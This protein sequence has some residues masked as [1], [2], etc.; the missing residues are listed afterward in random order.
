MRIM[1]TGAAG[2]L[3][4][5]LQEALDPLGEV[6]SVDVADFDITDSHACFSA[7]RG[8]RPDIVVHAAAY[9]RVDDCETHVEQAMRI[10]GTG[11]GIV[12][13]ACAEIK[14][15]MIYFSTDYVFDGQ[16]TTP[17]P[18]TADPAPLS[19]Y[20]RSKLAG[21]QEVQKYLPANHTIIR[22]AWL[23]GMHGKNFI[24]TIIHLAKSGKSL[25]VINDQYGCPTYTRD[26]AFGTVAILQAGFF[27]T[28]NI[29]NSG[30]ATWF[31]LAQYAVS[32]LFPDV[33]IQPVPTSGYPLPARRPAYSVLSTSVFRSVTGA[34]LPEWRNAVDRHLAKKYNDRG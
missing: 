28:I 10:N 22:T 6:L 8:F 11:T 34:P 24:D 33:E 25:R 29:T 7:I 2:M 14:A 12:A 15:K 9:T 21:E 5:D 1:I 17:Y 30:T 27:G 19:V 13:R 20:G 16:R 4:H 18:E 23:F 31:D 3:G 26:L 32:V